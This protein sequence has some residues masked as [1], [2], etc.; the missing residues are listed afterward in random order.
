MAGTGNFAPQDD[1]GDDQAFFGASYE[2]VGDPSQ[3]LAALHA[4]QMHQVKPKQQQLSAV[5]MQRKHMKKELE[6][7]NNQLGMKSSWVTYQWQQQQKKCHK[8]ALS[9][10]TSFVQ[11]DVKKH[12][13]KIRDDAKLYNNDGMKEAAAK[14]KQG[15]LNENNKEIL[16]RLFMVSV[17]DSPISKLNSAAGRKQEKRQRMDRIKALRQAKQM[18]MDY[19]NRENQL[20]IKRISQARS[21]F[22]HKEEKKF[23]ER[24]KKLRAAM[25]RVKDKPKKGRKGRGKRGR[26]KKGENN[27]RSAGGH[28]PPTEM[29]P[30]LPRISRKEDSNDPL[31]LNNSAYQTMVTVD[32]SRVQASTFVYA[33][34]LRFE[35]LDPRTNAV[36]GFELTNQ[37]LGQLI[38]TRFREL[39]GFS[40]KERIKGIT[41]RLPQLLQG[42]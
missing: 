7:W 2:I 35:L 9:T 38:D 13:R 33:D 42:Y 24:H 8:K 37:E 11:E 14:Y 4:A 19:I 10:M 12:M 18:K 22:D 30:T 20:M 5:E 31:K 28:L 16:K 3:S 1:Y 17:S 36:R 32:G 26:G 6:A 25:R 27:A 40:G 15:R 23:F 39:R 34:H 21:S 29:S 41:E